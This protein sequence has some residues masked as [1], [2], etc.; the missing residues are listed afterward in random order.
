MINRLVLVGRVT[1]AP[2]LNPAAGCTT[3]RLEVSHP[4][5]GG[6][7]APPESRTV[8]VEVLVRNRRRGEVLERYVQAQ[9]ALMVTGHLLPAEGVTRVE[10]EE[11]QFLPEG[12]VHVDLREEA[13]RTS[14]QATRAAA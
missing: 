4:T 11:W 2:G 5:F 13:F 1:Q 7:D 8:E 10:L 9:G 12:M 3:F 14:A 6:G